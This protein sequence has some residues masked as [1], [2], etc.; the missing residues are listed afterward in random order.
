ME[1]WR[2]ALKDIEYSNETD[3]YEFG[4]F[5]GN[6]VNWIN[7]A[8]RNAGKTPR[9]VFAL[10]SFCGLP[11]EIEIEKQESLQRGVDY[12]WSQGDFDSTKHFG[13]KTVKEAME[14]M[15]EFTKDSFNKET[16]LKII[17]GFYSELTDDMVELYDMKPAC[18][19]DL[20]ADMY[21]S[22][23]QALDFMFRNNLVVEGTIIG[24]DD[25]GGTLGWQTMSDGVSKAHKEIIDKYGV[26]FR[27][28]SIIGGAY[29]HV[30][31]I[32]KVLS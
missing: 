2:T 4:V 11:K 30:H 14:S 26:T 25:W 27:L 10:D 15:R 7:D 16:E 28:I 3:V 23:I 6:S 32:F 18:Y 5:T 17:P 29:P 21:L 19:I 20:D 1:G 31:T 24:Y 12:Q 13:V 22:T 8:L 9:K